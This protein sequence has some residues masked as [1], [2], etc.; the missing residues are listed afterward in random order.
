[1]FKVHI[2]GSHVA[3]VTSGQRT[4]DI[5]AP[6]YV[7]GEKRGEDQADIVYILTVNLQL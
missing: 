4:S 1:M 7:C 2:L 5:L 6:K 3:A